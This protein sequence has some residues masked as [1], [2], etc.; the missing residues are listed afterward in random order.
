M[1]ALNDLP[2][3]PRNGENACSGPTDE[4]AFKQRGRRATAYV[5]SASLLSWFPGH[6]QVRPGEPMGS[7]PAV[8][9]IGNRL[10]SALQSQSWI[11][12]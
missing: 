4:V 8:Q 5:S 2:H 1:Q 6:R 3:M 9:R 10:N 12:G 11:P 7:I